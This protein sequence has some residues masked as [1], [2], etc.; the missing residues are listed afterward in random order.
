[1]IFVASQVLFIAGLN[2]IFDGTQIISVGV[3][4]GLNDVKFPTLLSL[5]GYW[6][7]GLPFSY[8]LAFV[9]RAGAVGIWTGL[10]IGV[11]LQAVLLLLRLQRK[12]AKSMGESPRSAGGQAG[13]A[14]AIR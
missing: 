2:Q 3:L 10:L 1:V 12:F 11:I 13:Q 14:A 9:F 6:L 5:V 4:R 7:I 8:L